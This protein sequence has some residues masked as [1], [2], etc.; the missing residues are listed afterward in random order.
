MHIEL[1]PSASSIALPAQAPVR[2][3]PLMWLNAD[4]VLYVGLLGAPSV[5]TFGAYSIYL[6]LSKPHRISVAGGAWQEAEVSVVPPSVPHRI[7]AG[8][9][10]ICNILIEADSVAPGRLPDYLARGCGE[11]RD[12]AVLRGL[13]AALDR[14]RCSGTRQFPQTTDFDRSFFGEPLVPRAI[15][16]RIRASLA[17]IKDDPNSHT[18]AQDCADASHL[19]V[20]RF[21]HL[22]KAEV[23]TPFRSFRTWQRARSVLYYVT[24]NANLANIALDVGYP[25]STHFSHSIRQVYGLTPKS[26]FAGSRRL[27]LYGRAAAGSPRYQ[28]A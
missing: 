5:R 21:L 8:E 3:E 27:E 11:V 23:G 24:Q 17:R 16:R 22:F 2:H 10:M 13:R 1:D 4:R 25:D 26:I 12:E 9:R 6:S 20:S 15:D 28:F 18:S 7:A 14:F 19:S